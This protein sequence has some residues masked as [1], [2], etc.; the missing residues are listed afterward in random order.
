MINNV[1]HY[2]SE[3]LYTH[4][5]VIIMG[6]GGFIGNKNSAKLNIK[7]G[8]ITPPGKS[9]LFNTELKENDGLLINHI[10][11]QENLSQEKAKDK[12]IDFVNENLLKLNK[13]KS[14]RVNKIGIFSLSSENKII[15]SQDL[16]MNYNLSSY[17]LHPTINHSIKRNQKI[18]ID[19][20]LKDISNRNEFSSKK[21]LKIAAILIPLIGISLISITQQNG[22]N[23]L[24]IQMASILPIETSIDTKSEAYI[25]EKVVIISNEIIQPVKKEIKSTVPKNETTVVIKKDNFFVIAGAFSERKNA[26]NLVSRL[27]R[28]NYKASIVNDGN[29]KIMRVCYSKHISKELALIELKKIRNENPEAWILSL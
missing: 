21:L 12:V 25:D 20:S 13:Y 4:D 1:E 18:Q 24:Y 19:K 23:N 5:C 14:L 28:W 10:A 3:L 17:G 22:I 9:I 15:F 11:K 27:N 26:N 16:A 7:A 2:I 6:F 29:N 8:I